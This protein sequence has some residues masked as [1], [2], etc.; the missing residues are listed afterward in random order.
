MSNKIQITL[1]GGSTMLKTLPDSGFV[2]LPSILA[3]IPV[4]KST[5][6]AWVKEGRVKRPLKLGARVSVW[7]A[8]YIRDLCAEIATPKAA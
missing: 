8:Q 4:S 5:W 7:E 2:R 3:V 1:V 6:W